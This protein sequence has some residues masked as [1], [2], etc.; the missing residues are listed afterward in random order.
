MEEFTATIRERVDSLPTRDGREQLVQ[1]G[2]LLETAVSQQADAAK[3]A[4]IAHGLA[5]QLLATYPVPIAPKAAPD[6]ARGS[7]LYQEQC[8]ACHG[9]GGQ[10]RCLLHAQLDSAAHRIYRCGSCALA[11]PLFIV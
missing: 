10:R 3:V 11:K 1:Q 4:Q 2:Q 6:V 8:V 9:V 5:N 7:A